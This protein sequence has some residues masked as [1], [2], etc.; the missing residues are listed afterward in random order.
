M[1]IEMVHISDMAQRPLV[2]ELV[3]GLVD[4]GLVIVAAE[5]GAGKTFLGIHVGV[6]VAS[7]QLW[8]GRQVARGPVVYCIAEG[9]SHFTYR[10]TTAFDQLGLRAAD[11]PF[12]VIPHSI[13]M[14]SGDDGQVTK[15]IA[16]LVE[17]IGG[18]PEKP[19]LIVFDT[20]NRFMPGGDENKQADASALVRGCE[21]LVHNF[22]GTVML[23][24]HLSKGQGLARGSTVF[25]GAADQVL[26]AKAGQKGKVDAPVLWTTEGKDGKRKDRGPVKQWF[27]FKSV[28]MSKG[29]LVDKT[30]EDD[31]DNFYVMVTKYD[32]NG[33]EVQSNVVEDT[34]VME[35]CEPP[36]DADDVGGG[37]TEDTAALM[38]L[39]GQVGEIRV[40][41]TM[42]TLGWSTG[43]F[44]RAVDTL[45]AAGKIV[46]DEE[47]KGYVSAVPRTTGNPF[48]KQGR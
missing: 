16:E 40:R 36:A 23:M 15:E 33:E 39:I 2:E 41:K 6:H 19:R 9:V 4:Q 8:Q 46:K 21:F 44:Y 30:D 38:E 43:K 1:S 18:L 45:L 25:T 34:L 47:T 13:N 14:R 5:P 17:A 32:E 37:E 3:P 27:Q 11:H 7:G 31:F 42:E 48:V 28:A 35:P 10:I 20:L 26:L 12:Y 22:G 29:F 24:H